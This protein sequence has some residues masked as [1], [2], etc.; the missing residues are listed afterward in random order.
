M[1]ESIATCRLKAGVTIPLAGW[2]CAATM[3]GP[4]NET[5]SSS[6]CDPCDDPGLFHSALEANADVRTEFS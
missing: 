4:F 2:L 5:L 1:L 3:F 6:R